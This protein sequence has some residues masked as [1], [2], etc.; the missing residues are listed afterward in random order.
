MEDLIWMVE[1]VK[2]ERLNRSR[3]KTHYIEP[4]NR[5]VPLIEDREPVDNILSELATKLTLRL[6]LQPPRRVVT[7][8][9]WPQHGDTR[10][11]RTSARQAAP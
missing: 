1:V 3:S 9:R 8:S 11:R 5:P 7:L 2:L 6:F 4:L 10:L